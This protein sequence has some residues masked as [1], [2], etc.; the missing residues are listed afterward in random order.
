M[1]DEEIVKRKREIDLQIG[2]RIRQSRSKVNIS[3]TALGAAIGVGSSQMSRY[4]AGETSCTAWQLEIIAEELGV[5]IDYLVH[6]QTEDM[7]VLEIARKIKK[8][9]VQF[10]MFI[11]YG[12]EGH[13]RDI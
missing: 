13:I 10:R 11:Q 3:Q 9:P 6:G 5:T 12:I 1:L 2:E 4:E 7:M 8:L